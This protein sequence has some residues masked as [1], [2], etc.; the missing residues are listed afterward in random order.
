LLKKKEASKIRT[1]RKR[2]LA[3]ENLKYMFGFS[4][5]LAKL[6]CRSNF[7]N[8]TASETCTKIFNFFYY[9]LDAVRFSV[10]YF[11]LR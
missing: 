3:P 1:K 10:A 9:L 4:V 2:L 11:V 8:F 5:S 6:L 7:A